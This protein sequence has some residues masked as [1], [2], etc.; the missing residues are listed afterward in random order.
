MGEHQCEGVFESACVLR[1]IPDRNPSQSITNTIHHNSSQSITIHH[2]PSQSGNRS[3]ALSV[4]A[5]DEDG[6]ALDPGAERRS[7]PARPHDCARAG[8]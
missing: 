4:P 1:A 7:L 5:G 8:S 3:G 6:D 2:N